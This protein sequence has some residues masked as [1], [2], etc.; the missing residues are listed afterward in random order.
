MQHHFTIS[1]RVNPT[2]INKYSI[3]NLNKYLILNY[4][5]VM[6]SGFS[7][8]LYFFHIRPKSLSR[9]VAYV[10]QS[11]RGESM[12]AFHTLALVAFKLG[13][14]SHVVMEHCRGLTLFIKQKQFL[15]NS[16]WYRSLISIPPL[17]KKK[18]K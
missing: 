15:R 5:S 7:P 18:W 9:L 13:I 2:E 3:L 12:R 6:W 16:R 11:N 17:H 14:K 4:H 1:S 8:P 10:L